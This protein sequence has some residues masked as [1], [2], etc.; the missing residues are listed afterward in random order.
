[1]SH[2]SALSRRP[3]RNTLTAAA[4]EASPAG[5]FSVGRAMRFQ[6]DAIALADCP[7]DSSHDPKVWR[8]SAGSAGSS[9]RRAS[10][11]RTAAARSTGL[12]GLYRTSVEERW[13]GAGRP[14][15]LMNAG[16]LPSRRTGTRR[17]DW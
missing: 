12:S 7:C 17:R 3:V 8:S 4:S 14:V 5:R 11:P 6:S 13:S 2:A 16:R 9:R 10:A 15:R 1:M